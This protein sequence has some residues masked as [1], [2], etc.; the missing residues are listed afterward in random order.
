[1]L[2]VLD[3]LGWSGNVLRKINMF[4]RL[5]EMW[6]MSFFRLKIVD[7]RIKGEQGKVVYFGRIGIYQENEGI[8]KID[9][10][11]FK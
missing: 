4:D 9:L 2:E 3:N 7:K 6:K 11:K 10:F 5:K 8:Q 1:M